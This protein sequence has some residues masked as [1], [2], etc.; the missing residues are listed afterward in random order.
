MSGGKALEKG[1]N[2]AEDEN[3]MTEQ[4]EADSKIPATQEQITALLDKGGW[5]DKWVSVRDA[6]VWAH[7]LGEEEKAE[8]AGSTEDL[9]PSRSHRLKGGI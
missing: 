8:G 5:L 2:Q 6:D 4:E 9:R 3:G 1:Q 7:A